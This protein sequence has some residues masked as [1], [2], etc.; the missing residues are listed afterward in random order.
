MTIYKTRTFKL[1]DHLFFTDLTLPGCTY[2]Y[3]SLNMEIIVVASPDKFGQ[4]AAYFQTPY[5][6]DNVLDLGSKLP[7]KVANDLFPEY[8]KKFKY[9]L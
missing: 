7:E 6:G 2:Q 4:W 9:R 3:K 5:S 1:K 8:A